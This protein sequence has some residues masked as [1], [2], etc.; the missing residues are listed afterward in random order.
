MAENKPLAFVI[1]ASFLLGWLLPDEKS[2]GIDSIFE[3]YANGEIELYSTKLLPFEV[4]NGLRSAFLRKRLTQAKAKKLLHEFLKLDIV[5]DFVEYKL[6]WKI[7]QKYSLTCYD[8]SYV[9]LAYNRKIGLLTMDNELKKSASN[10]TK[11]KH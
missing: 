7:S 10:Y 11:I 8:S 9:A 5:L 2:S 3:Q 1:D 6:L 4:A